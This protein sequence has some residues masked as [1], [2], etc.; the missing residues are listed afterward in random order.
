MRAAA[1]RNPP[2]A[3]AAPACWWR[4]PAGSSS[5]PTRRAG[6]SSR[7]AA[8]APQT[9]GCTA[10]EAHGEAFLGLLAVRRGRCLRSHVAHRLNPDPAGLRDR[11]E[12][13]RRRRRGCTGVSRLGSHSES[14]SPTSA[15]RTVAGVMVHAGWPVAGGD[16]RWTASWTTNVKRPRNRRR[17]TLRNWRW[18]G[19]P[20]RFVR[21]CVKGVEGANQRKADPGG[22]R[23]VDRA[24]GILGTKASPVQTNTRCLQHRVIGRSAG[25]WAG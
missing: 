15:A 3:P 8:A 1:T 13:A 23:T 7:A 24:R 17:L 11:R 10:S 19:R 2:A 14:A 5:A 25:A 18:T 9:H 12:G 22:L 21:P 20:R 4:P 16:G 6:R